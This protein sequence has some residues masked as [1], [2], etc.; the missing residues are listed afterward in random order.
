[1]RCPKCGKEV[2]HDSQFCE[3][4]GSEIVHGTMKDSASY[5]SQNIFKKH[6]NIGDRGKKIIYCTLFFL[7]L[8]LIFLCVTKMPIKH[9]EVESI[10]LKCDNLVNV[11][12]SLGSLLSILENDVLATQ[13]MI[14]EE[15]DSLN[16]KE[17][18]FAAENERLITECLKETEQFITNLRASKYREH[19]EAMS[20]YKEVKKR[21]PHA[22]NNVYIDLGLPSRTKWSNQNE[23]GLYTQDEAISIFGKN[24]LPTI[25]ELKELMEKCSWQVVGR[26]YKV[27]GPNGNYIMLHAN[28]NGDNCTYAYRVGNYG[29]YWSSTKKEESRSYYHETALGFY[30]DE[31]HP[32]LWGYQPEETLSVRLVKR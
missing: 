20:A 27:V 3:Y 2:A 30:I 28:G 16:D 17:K 7:S 25:Y 31:R 24:N 15:Y 23:N 4:C 22:Q 19:T 18:L 11:S 13:E 8:L 9:R 5:R 21:S 29:T 12:D 10:K 14:K 26:Q 6:W 1:M 32:F